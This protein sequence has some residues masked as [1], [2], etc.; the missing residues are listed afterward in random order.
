MFVFDGVSGRGFEVEF[1]FKFEFEFVVVGRLA[2]VVSINAAG[3]VVSN[4]VGSNAS[5]VKFSVDLVG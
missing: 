3:V 2:E 1:E 4:C 5:D